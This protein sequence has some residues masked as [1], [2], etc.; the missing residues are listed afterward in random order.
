MGLLALSASSVTVAGAG[1]AFGTWATLRIRQFGG[2]YNG[3]F[4]VL[5]GTVGSSGQIWRSHRHY[6]APMGVVGDR[7]QGFWL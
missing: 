3:R 7:A 5:M 6:S 4:A 1:K 2:V